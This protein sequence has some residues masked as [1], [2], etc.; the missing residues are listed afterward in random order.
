MLYLKVAVFELLAQIPVNVVLAPPLAGV[1][2]SVQ[3]GGGHGPASHAWLAAGLGAVQVASADGAPSLR[4]QATDCVCV[5][6]PQDAL[7]A[8]K[9]EATQPYVQVV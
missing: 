1:I 6:G 3:V 9:P 4:L 7:Q 2:E 5:P 8:P